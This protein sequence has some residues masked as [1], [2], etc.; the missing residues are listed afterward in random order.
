MTGKRLQVKKGIEKKSRLLFLKV[1][2]I[3]YTLTFDQYV[4]DKI[5]VNSA[6]EYKFDETI[7]MIKEV[8]AREAE[9][10]RREGIA[11][12]EVERKHLEICTGQQSKRKLGKSERKKLKAEQIRQKAERKH[13]AEITRHLVRLEVEKKWQDELKRL[14]AEKRRQEWLAQREEKR[15]RQEE[16]VRQKTEKKR[17]E[18]LARQEAERKRQEEIACQEAERKRQEE[19][20]RQEVERKSKEEIARQETERKRQE[21]IARQEAERKSKEE[22]A[23]QDAERKRKEE[24]KRQKIERKYKERVELQ[25]STDVAYGNH[26]GLNV[27][28]TDSEI[29]FRDVQYHELKNELKA[30]VLDDYSEILEDHILNFFEV[31]IKYI[32]TKSNYNECFEELNILATN[33]EQ[34][35]IDS[36]IIDSVFDGIAVAIDS[37]LFNTNIRYVKKILLTLIDALPFAGSFSVPKNDKYEYGINWHRLFIDVHNTNEPLE[38]EEDINGLDEEVNREQRLLSKQIDKREK[39]E[40][41]IED[42]YNYLKTQNRPISKD[43]IKEK[44]EN[45]SRDVF[46]G[47]KQK[48]GIVDYGKKLFFFDNAKI[49][50]VDL[51]ILEDNILEFIADH[52]GICHCEMLYE[53]Y[54]YD[55]RD[56]FD[57]CF[58]YDK[59]G[60]WGVLQC[61]FRNRLSFS[62][63]FVSE[64]DIE[65]VDQEERLRRYVSK[66]GEISIEDINAYAK[67]NHLKVSSMLRFIESLNHSMLLK[68][69]EKL[70][71]FDKVGITRDKVYYIEKLI[72]Q[73]LRGD[74]GYKAFRDL[75]CVN[76]FPII[77]CPWDEWLLYSAIN[78][79]GHTLY[80]YTTSSRFAL[81]L[82]VVSLYSWV[83]EETLSAISKR[84]EGSINQVMTNKIDDLENLDDL[85]E[86]EIELDDIDD[87]NDLDVDIWEEV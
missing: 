73:E 26:L 84:Y 79:W 32:K 57:N 22:I 18:R 9:R 8:S 58:I 15:K 17:Q 67:N 16:I 3:Y 48:Q 19:I 21:E 35:G 29:E 13:Q 83:S 42:I 43:Y 46:E 4:S 85:I 1:E 41:K 66:Y 59:K 77:N 71:A 47:I 52:E 86:D 72:E 33:S 68:N 63:Y 50:K 37:N 40:R 82:P 60:F 56:L 55:Y 6:E 38:V 24:Q 20:A 54:C 87:L 69:R 76:Q 31:Y 45:I 28:K 7:K 61:R 62:K 30:R 12:Q 5:Y 27:Q 80:L 78:K 65:I 74:E 10:K 75:K 44:F 51:A 36:R 53:E 64:L 70:V 23:C 14:E 2:R 49:D 39:I 25:K 34:L 11:R 81:A